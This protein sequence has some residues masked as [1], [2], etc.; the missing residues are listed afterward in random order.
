MNTSARMVKTLMALIAAM[1][2]SAGLLGWLDPGRREW[3]PLESEAAIKARVDEAIQQ[4]VQV[5]PGTWNVVEVVAKRNDSQGVLLASQVLEPDAHFQIDVQGG[6]MRL[7]LWTEQRPALAS[8]TEAIRIRVIQSSAS[9]ELL[10][11]Q[12]LALQVLLEGLNAHVTGKTGM[13]QRR[14]G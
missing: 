7:P 3:R 11:P 13:G 5:R 12:K 8:A 2:G 10:E 4:G 6:V 14:R 1:T 9:T